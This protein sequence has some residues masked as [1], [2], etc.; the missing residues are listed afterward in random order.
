[1]WAGLAAW[2]AAIDTGGSGL[3]DYRVYRDDT[4]LVTVTGTS[5]SDTTVAPGTQYFYQVSARDNSDNESSR[6]A[7]LAVTTLDDT[8]PPAVPTGLTTTSVQ[9]TS[10]ALAWNASTDTG[11]SGLS[12]YRVYRD[13]TLLAT[14]TGTTY[15]DTTVVGSTQYS[16]Q[17]SSRDNANNESTR[18]TELAVTTPARRPAAAARARIVSQR[19]WREEF[20]ITSSPVAGSRKKLPLIPVTEGGIPVTIAA[21]LTFVND[22]RAARARPR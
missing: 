18:S 12:D 4:L 3:R 11:G 14:V 20:I 19:R 13:N 5:Y 9:E 10:V 8:T 15:N 22:G 6:S 7:V 1:M 16:Y 21:L 17:V 2:S